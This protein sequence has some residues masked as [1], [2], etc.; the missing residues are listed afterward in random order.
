[1]NSSVLL[2]SNSVYIPSIV[3]P[4]G[5]NVDV[6][7][8]TYMFENV[9]DL[10][11]VNRVDIFDIVHK[12]GQR[13]GGKRGAFVHMNYWENNSSTELIL[14]ELIKTG[15]CILWLT[16][17][18]NRGR[19]CFWTLKKMNREPVQETQLNVH[20]LAEKI[21]E[22][23][24]I[25]K[26]RD[27]QIECFQD[28]VDW[29]HNKI[30]ELENDINNE[31]NMVNE[32]DEEHEFNDYDEEGELIKSRPM[33]INELNTD[34]DYDEEGELIQSHPMSVDYEEGEIIQSYPMSVDELNTAVDYGPF[35]DSSKIFN[36][37]DLNGHNEFK[38]GI[39]TW[40][41]DD[42]DDDYDDYN[43]DYNER[44][45]LNAWYRYSIGGDVNSKNFTDILI[46]SREEDLLNNIDPFI[47]YGYDFYENPNGSYS[48]KCKIDNNNNNEMFKTT[49]DMNTRKQFTN[50][51]CNN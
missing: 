40:E 26:D 11:K 15:K 24:E 16:H 46:K 35:D 30:E 51:L 17:N 8:I 5:H 10:G 43:Y 38:R 20:Q 14:E 48:M 33:S 2:S 21:R 28:Q 25:I 32:Y 18:T 36:N 37:M 4:T 34:V 3:A 1:M 49:L 44:P 27:N 31:Y 50:Y 47:T 22:L 39:S 13:A 7:Y 29:L 41:G 6:D 12:N 19:G 9:W 23:E 45:I 42:Y